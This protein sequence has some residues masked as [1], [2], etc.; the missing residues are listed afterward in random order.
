MLLPY[1]HDQVFPSASQAE[2]SVMWRNEVD[3]VFKTG[4][5]EVTES[6]TLQGRISFANDREYLITVNAPATR[7]YIS[8]DSDQRGAVWA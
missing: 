2:L 1:Q 3:S 4:S 8:M 5:G 6:E 7:L